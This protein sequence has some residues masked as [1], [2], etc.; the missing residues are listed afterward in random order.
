[1]QRRQQAIRAPAL[2]TGTNSHGNPWCVRVI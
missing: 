2:W 1:M